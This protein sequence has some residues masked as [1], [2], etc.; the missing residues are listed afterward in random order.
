MTI[1]FSKKEIFLKTI[2]AVHRLVQF[3][4]ELKSLI[5]I[6]LHSDLFLGDRVVRTTV[7]LCMSPFQ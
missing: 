2:M 6:R 4:V 7:R 1:H 3:G 5:L